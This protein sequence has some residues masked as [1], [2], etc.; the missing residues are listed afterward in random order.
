[1]EVGEVKELEI[2]DFFDIVSDEKG[3]YE[4]ETPQG[5][6]EIGDLIKKSNKKCFLIRTKSGLQLG[7]SDDHYVETSDG[8]KNLE[9]IDIHNC[10]VNT[11]NGEEEIVAKEYLEDQ[12]TFDLEVKNDEHKYFANGIVSHNTGKTTIGHVICNNVPD[13]TVI[14]ITP[15]LIAENGTR[16]LSSVKV[17]YK[18]ADFVS[19][20]IIILEDLDLF[21]GDRDGMGGGDLRLGSLMNILD[22]VNSVSN[23]ITIG[24]TNRL[25][26][27]E[28]ALRNRPGRFDRIIE[29]PS[30]NK[31][32]RY[33]MF[34]N[35]LLD[36]KV[37]NK[38]IDYIVEN[39][40]EWTGAEAQEF[41]NTLNLNFIH[42]KKKTKKVD[43]KL[44]D[45][46]IETMKMFGIGEISS[47][48]GFVKRS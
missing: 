8:W 11:K 19:P 42:S 20:C 4:I 38:T 48:F 17:L 1:M 25:N 34:K 28:K 16:A 32:L 24:T 7:G 15:E 30:L 29:I 14:W 37:S 33:K 5:W 21:G 45:K 46:V 22:G 40:D 3:I 13:H 12:D 9:E 43:I 47:E 26:S 6:I 44:V 27:I 36:W 18:L 31:E 35:R 39:T 41:I 2:N 23:A 10:C